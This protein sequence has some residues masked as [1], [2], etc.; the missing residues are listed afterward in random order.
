MWS[1]ASDRGEHGRQADA[2]VRATLASAAAANLRPA[3]RVTGPRRALSGP[4]LS[5]LILTSPQEMRD[6]PPR[7]GPADQQRRGQ[8]AAAHRAPRHR[9]GGDLAAGADG[10]AVRA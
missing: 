5:R 8:P 6:G 2:D 10:A 3:G 7:A 9:I 1:R 4:A